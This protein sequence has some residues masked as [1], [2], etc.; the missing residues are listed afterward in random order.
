MLIFVELKFVNCLRKKTET[1][2]FEMRSS[3]FTQHSTWSL[4]PSNLSTIDLRFS[5]RMSQ[6]RNLHLS[7]LPFLCSAWSSHRT[8]SHWRKIAH[9]PRCLLQSVSDWLDRTHTYKVS[10]TDWSELTLTKCLTDWTELTLTKCLWLTGPH[11]HLQSVC[12]WLDR[13]HTYKVSVTDWTELTLTKCP[14]LT[15]PNSHSLG[16]FQ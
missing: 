5:A 11:S 16:R 1:Q 2:V 8:L 3:T 9:E 15:G 14:W 6:Q 10:V 4:Y 13:T 12:D 7:R